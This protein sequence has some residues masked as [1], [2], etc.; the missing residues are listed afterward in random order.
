M[1][2]LSNY[3]IYTNKD[4]RMRAYNK[5]THAVTS[6][7]RLLMELTLGRPLLKTEDVHHK[8]ENPLNNNIEN[9]EVIDHV[10]HEKQHMLEKLIKCPPK[11][12][13]K[14]MIC[15]VCE[16]IFTWT[17][18]QQCSYKSRTKTTAKTRKFDRQPPCCSKQ[19]S[20]KYAASIQYNTHIYKEKVKKIER[21][22]HI[23]KKTFI[24]GSAS[25]YR[26]RKGVN[27]IPEPCCSRKCIHALRRQLGLKNKR[28]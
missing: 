2:D 1:L 5:T 19:C 21:I 6:Y 25:Q 4:G 10:E 28:N 12:Y 14:E 9:L 20:G 17:A 27:E 24:W 23:C 13:D 16:K 3:N 8:D 7:P 18:R 22:C 11:Y 15:P 26:F